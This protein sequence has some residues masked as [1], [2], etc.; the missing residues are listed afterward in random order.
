MAGFILKQLATY[1]IWGVDWGSVDQF[2]DMSM[3]VLL[4]YLILKGDKIAKYLMFKIWVICM[5]W[6]EVNI[7]CIYNKHLHS[8]EKGKYCFFESITIYMVL[9]QL[10]LDHVCESKNLF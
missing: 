3:H 9:G 8:S 4:G 6:R 10:N 2:Y 5:V 7:G 1:T